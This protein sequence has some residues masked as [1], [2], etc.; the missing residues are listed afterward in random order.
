MVAEHHSPSIVCWFI[1]GYCW[2]LLVIVGYCWLL[3]V[4]LGSIKV[5]LSWA[6]AAAV[7]VDLSEIEI[8]II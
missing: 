2:L 4:I 3:L 7:A 1:V 8:Q 6:A 5:H